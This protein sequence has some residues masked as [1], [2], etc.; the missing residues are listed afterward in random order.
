MD[1][2]ESATTTPDPFKF[3]AAAVVT[4]QFVRKHTLIMSLLN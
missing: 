4:G 1:F 2:T 3:G